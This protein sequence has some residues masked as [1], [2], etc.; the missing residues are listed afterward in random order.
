MQKEL[1]RGLKL[2]LLL[3]EYHSDF[4]PNGFAIFLHVANS[5]GL[6]SGDIIEKLKMPK[7]TVSRN[8]RMLGDRVSPTREG[9]NLVRL[10]HDANDYRV[11]RAY[12]TERGKEFLRG[13]EEALK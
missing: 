1:K 6:S 4:P 9:L 3:R 5:E 12:L 7:A 8:L 11:R 2:A 10:E 13:V